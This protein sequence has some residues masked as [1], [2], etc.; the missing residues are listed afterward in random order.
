MSDYPTW[1]QRKA[2]NNDGMD[3]DWRPDDPP[4]WSTAPVKLPPTEPKPKYECICKET[5]DSPD[6]RMVHAVDCE[7][8][9]LKC[10]YDLQ[11]RQL[12]E[13]L[14]ATRDLRLEIDTRWMP[15]LMKAQKERDQFQ[16]DMMNRHE[17]LAILVSKNKELHKD[18]QNLW[19]RIRFF[20][21]AMSDTRNLTIGE[22]GTNMKC[23]CGRKNCHELN[24]SSGDLVL[25]VSYIHSQQFQD[26]IKALKEKL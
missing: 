19:D 1:A 22:D 24:L 15:A 25:V 10:N 18:F 9:K 2:W 11:A 5:F 8:W 23:T 3:P 12:K 13:S 21:K 16:H 17:K 14:Q 26:L 6:D 7:H 4:Q 20:T